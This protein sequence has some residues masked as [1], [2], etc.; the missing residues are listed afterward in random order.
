MPPKT[1]LV[2]GSDE[3]LVAGGEN[4]KSDGKGA[5]GAACSVK[6][7]EWEAREISLYASRPPRRSEAG[8]KSV[9]LLRSK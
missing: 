7:D 4:G 3:W 2:L 9:G 6:V 1:L 8:G 5:W